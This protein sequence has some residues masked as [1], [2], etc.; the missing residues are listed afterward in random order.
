MDNK[1]QRATLE[2]II[3]KYEAAPLQG[4]SVEEMLKRTEYMLAK[5][6]LLSDDRKK[7]VALNIKRG[8]QCRNE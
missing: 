3:L 7:A 1:T 6:M 2:K 8:R 4:N 5:R